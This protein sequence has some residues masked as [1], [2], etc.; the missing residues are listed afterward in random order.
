VARAQHRR[1][2]RHAGV[3]RAPAIQGWPD[4]RSA[5]AGSGPTT[6][7]STSASAST[8]SPKRA[9]GTAISRSSCSRRWCPRR[10]RKPSRQRQATVPP[11]LRG[12]RPRPVA[13]RPTPRTRT[14]TNPRPARTLVSPPRLAVAQMSERGRREKDCPQPRNRGRRRCNRRAPV[15]ICVPVLRRVR[16]HALRVR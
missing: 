6:H 14:R 2:R 9:V 5:S 12:V 8:T 7:S 4:D 3:S 11:S 15:F 16:S 10:D 1:H 13:T